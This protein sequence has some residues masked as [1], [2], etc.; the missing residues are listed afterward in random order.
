M[1]DM[2][3]SLGGDGLKIDY[4]LRE[5][6]PSRIICEE[7]K[8]INVD[9]IIVGSSHKSTVSKLYSGTTAAYVIEHSDKPV[10]TIPEQD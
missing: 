1:K 5:G 6:V 8:K 4:I 10:L 3:N 9:L 2:I 7:S